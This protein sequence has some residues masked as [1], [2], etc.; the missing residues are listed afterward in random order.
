[1]SEIKF[2]VIGDFHYKK[3]MYAATVRDL[4]TMFAE[5]NK[6][7]VNFC[8]HIGDFCNDYKGS[9]ELVSK[10]L[11]NEYNLSVFGVYGNHELE[12]ADNSMQRVTP[13]LS[14]RNDL[15]VYGTESGKIEDGSVAYSYYDTAG[16]R[17]V[18][19]DTNYSL[20]PDGE[21]EHNRTKSY[22]APRE[23]SKSGSLG[24][25][26]IAWLE[27]VLDDAAKN[28]LRCVV[29]SHVAFSGVWA[30]SPDTEAVKRIFK[31]ANAKRAGTVLLAINGHLHSNNKAFTEGGVSYFDCPASINGWWQSA[32]F[33]PYKE[34]DEE[35]P[36]YTFDYLDYDSDGALKGSYKMP[37]SKLSMGAQSLFYESPL[38]AIV[39]VT[40]EGKIK[41]KGRKTNF[42]YGVSIPLAECYD[43]E[44]KDFEN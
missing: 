36:K 21:Y 20:T 37:Y 32:Q 35:N 29:F 3:K 31:E 2:L 19:L 13:L 24:P 8:V 23:N 43:P 4:E 38:F 34:E 7:N 42:S 40:D 39:T 17:L 28:A 14:N 26:Q 33:Y 5:A 12:S 11:N 9:P 22:G 1:M 15:L 10:Y 27:S 18:F 44:I 41:I 30:S 16:F 25:R 6:E